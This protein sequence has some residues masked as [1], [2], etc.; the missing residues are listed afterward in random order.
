MLSRCGAAVVLCTQ[1]AIFARG[2]RAATPRFSQQQNFVLAL[3]LTLAFA[4][5][6]VVLPVWRPDVLGI[7]LNWALDYVGLNLD[8]TKDS[9]STAS[10][11]EEEPCRYDVRVCCVPP[12]RAPSTVT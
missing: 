10:C 9:T 8:S 6:C 3:V 12:C 7:K 1:V 4:V 5:C 11:E 2:E